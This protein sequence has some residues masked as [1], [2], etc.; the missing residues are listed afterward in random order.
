MTLL[1]QVLAL[2][3]FQRRE[4]SAAIQN[5]YAT[6]TCIVAPLLTRKYVVGAKWNYPLL[7]KDF[8]ELNNRYV[9][10]DEIK[11]FTKKARINA[12]PELDQLVEMLEP[13]PLEGLAKVFEVSKG[14]WHY[15]T[16]HKVR[17]A[18]MHLFMQETTVED[19]EGYVSKA[20]FPKSTLHDLIDVP[21]TKLPFSSIDINRYGLPEFDSLLTEPNE[22]ALNILKTGLSSRHLVRS[23]NHYN[24]ALIQ[25]EL[26]MQT[27]IYYKPLSKQLMPKHLINVQK[28]I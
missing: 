26:Y 17:Q 4:I 20:W 7:E 14:T 5:S 2:P 21:R 24:Y 11:K 16:T 18:A 9:P 6:T 13:V 25:L 28:I 23:N 3:E 22:L 8:K 27:G 19:E 10:L 15:S 1:E 12:L